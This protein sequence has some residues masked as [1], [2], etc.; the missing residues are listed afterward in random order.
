MMSEV[1]SFCVDNY[2]SIKP[3]RLAEIGHE[4][5]GCRTR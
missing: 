4:T 5:N 2:S 1:S 3:S